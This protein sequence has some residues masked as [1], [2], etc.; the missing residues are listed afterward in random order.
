MALLQSLATRRT[1]KKH[2]HTFYNI[3]NNSAVV[4]RSWDKI[5]AI[6]WPGEIIHVLYMA[7]AE[8]K[9]NYCFERKAT[10]VITGF[11]AGFLSRLKNGIWNFFWEN[12]LGELQRSQDTYKLLLRTS[13]VTGNP[14]SWRTSEVTGNPSSD[15]DLDVYTNVLINYY[16][17]R[18]WNFIF[19]N[20]VWQVFTTH[21]GPLYYFKIFDN[22]YF[23]MTRGNNT[24]L[25]KLHH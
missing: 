24:C 19:S 13:E 14:T 6:W 16:S 20:E 11:H 17:F 2:S 23:I 10:S 5:V 3:P 7:S 15:Y 4:N 22:K 9:L 25:I 18:I 1:P 12:P 21:T 8:K